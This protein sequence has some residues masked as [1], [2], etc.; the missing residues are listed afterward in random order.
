MKILRV[1]LQNLNSLIGE[2]ELDLSRQPFIDDGLFAIVGKT[3]AGKTTLLDAITLGL[4]GKMAR[5]QSDSPDFG[6]N[7]SS[8]QCYAEVE[9]VT[10]RGRFS[11]RWERKRARGQLEGDLQPVKRYVYNEEGE[12]IAE[13]IREVDDKIVELT[14]LDYERFLR[15]AMLAQGE[16]DQ[17]LSAKPKERSELLEKITGTSIY[18]NLGR[19]CFEKTRDA[20]NEVE[21][22]KEIMEGIIRLPKEELEEKKRDLDSVTKTLTEL[23]E[24][25]DEQQE[26]YDKVNKL[27]DAREKAKQ[28]SE[29]IQSLKLES[30]KWKSAFE[31]LE[32]HEKGQQLV[33]SVEK[34]KQ[35]QETLKNAKT[36]RDDIS[37][38][39]KKADGVKQKSNSILQSALSA[40]I[41]KC[42]LKLSEVRGSLE[43]KNEN[44]EKCQNWLTD[45]QSDSQLKDELQDLLHQNGN[46]SQ[47]RK[48]SDDA[49]QTLIHG[50]AALLGEKAN[51]SDIEEAKDTSS[52][53]SAWTNLKNEIDQKVAQRELSRDQKLKDF[54]LRDDH[55]RKA[56]KLSVLD[57]HM[58]LLEEGKPCPMC[59]SEEH[60]MPRASGGDDLQPIQEARNVALD[61]LDSSK[62]ELREAQQTRDDISKSYDDYFDLM[63]KKQDEFSSFRSAL[64]PFGATVPEAGMEKDLEETLKEREKSYSKHE[65]D[66]NDLSVKIKEQTIQIEPLQNQIKD[67][68][69]ELK[70]LPQIKEEGENQEKQKTDL[71]EAKENFS[72]ASSSLEGLKIAAV[73]AQQQEENA[74]VIL[75]S[76]STIMETKINESSFGS[77]KEWEESRL[78][79]QEVLEIKERR[80]KIES[81]KLQEAGKLSSANDEIKVLVE[82]KIP[83]GKE[84]EKFLREHNE[85]REK[86]VNFSEEKGRLD[87]LINEQVGHWE[88]WKSK[89]TEIEQKR[90]VLEDWEKL[91]ELIGCSTGK[92][93]RT[94]AQS[95]S[96]D[97]LVF[98]ANNHLKELEPRYRIER[99]TDENNEL[100]LLIRDCFEGG[101]TRP[102]SSLSG[103]ETFLASLALALGVSDLARGENRID[104]LFVDEGFGSLDP[105]CLEKAVGVLQELRHKNKTVGVISHVELLKDRISTQVEVVVLPE[106]KRELRIS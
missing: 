55:L 14:G 11:S 75:K 19:L 15:S 98:L 84:A 34:F 9:F 22:L 6:M 60:P 35:A 46:F 5:Y 63:E 36:H 51:Y 80:T 96:L 62:E 73:N 57:Q 65:K 89:E 39:I 88:R 4:Y 37:E 12:P 101:Q 66:R 54:N 69:K 77:L 67:L 31:K 97:A 64:Q 86:K 102:V 13:K 41:E 78:S 53:K 58:H 91:N 8:A 29:K 70:D 104:T 83:E 21:Q 71:R 10:S 87:Q 42:E 38:Q 105:D 25:W 79:D 59:G 48:K 44:L 27:S 82:D 92:K 106:G 45:H 95:H 99:E 74:A 81:S 90:K 3:G 52:I 16:F 85:R 72:N 56:Q 49:L 40:E 43:E 93:F 32:M 61:E 17:F 100:G 94:F 23:S 76:E 26:I 33:E 1:R 24:E 2:H 7:R 20:R 18:S 47:T 50:L 103:G 30:D 68:R 28:A